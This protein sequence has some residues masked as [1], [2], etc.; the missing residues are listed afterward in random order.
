M[1]KHREWHICSWIFCVKK[2]PS[3]LQCN[4]MHILLDF[5]LREVKRLLPNVKIS[6]EIEIE[7]LNLI[8]NM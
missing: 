5:G 4:E 1:P 3:S 6:K 8:H 2:T 7:K